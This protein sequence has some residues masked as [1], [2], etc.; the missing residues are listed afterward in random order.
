MYV[1]WVCIINSFV[2]LCSDFAIVPFQ[3]LPKANDIPDDLWIF[4]PPERP[5]AILQLEV[6]DNLEELLSPSPLRWA[7]KGRLCHQEGGNAAGA[8]R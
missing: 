2:N 5:H 6:V 4:F 7:C 3:K 8:T 1:V